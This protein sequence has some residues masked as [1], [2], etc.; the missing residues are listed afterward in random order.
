MDTA[1][2]KEF[3]ALA[4]TQNFWEASELLFM[5]ESTL[6]KHI[7]K[8]ES[9]RMDSIFDLVAQHMAISLLTNRHFYASGQHLKLVPLAPAL[10]SQTYLCYLKNTTLNATATAMLEYMKGVYKIR[11]TDDAFLFTS[12]RQIHP[13]HHL[14]RPHSRNLCHICH[15]HNHRPYRHRH[16]HHRSRRNNCSFSNCRSF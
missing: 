3:L 8:L 13:M 11:L 12:L 9:K 6:S 7:K 14:L 4:E 15:N 2:L 5:N 16:S 1:S 10:Y